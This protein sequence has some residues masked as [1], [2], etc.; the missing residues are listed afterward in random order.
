MKG[1]SSIFVSFAI[2]AVLASLPY[3]LSNGK[4]I[5]QAAGP[6]V[7]GQ[8]FGGGQ[9]GGQFPPQGGPGFGGGQA[10]FPGQGQRFGMGAMVNSMTTTGEFLFASSGDTIYKIRI[11]SMKI[12]GQTK[13][14]ATQPNFG[15]NGVPSQAGGPGP[16]IRRNG[17]QAGGGQVPPVKNPA[18]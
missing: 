16:G 10:G 13:L 9:Q 4:T 17:G 5:A 7:G 2:G 8:G 6:A 18:K 11:S 12:E 14:P 1:K 15:G 3:T